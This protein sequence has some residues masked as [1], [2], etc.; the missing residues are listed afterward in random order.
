[1]YPYQIR[2]IAREGANAAASRARD[3]SNAAAQP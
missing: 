3:V 2:A 1:M